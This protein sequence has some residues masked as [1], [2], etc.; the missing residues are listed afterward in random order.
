MERMLIVVVNDASLIY[1]RLS[2][3]ETIISFFYTTYKGEGARKL[4]QRIQG[5]YAGITRDSIH[6][7]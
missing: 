2:E 5:S 6:A 1:P 3:R 7:T 4:V